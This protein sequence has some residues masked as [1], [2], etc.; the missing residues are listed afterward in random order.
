MFKKYYLAYGSNLNIHKMKERCPNA[1]AISK[2]LLN[3]HRLVY[4]GGDVFMLT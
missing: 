4:R 1:K 3:N 2:V